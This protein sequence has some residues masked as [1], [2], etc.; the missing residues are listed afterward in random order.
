MDVWS[1][2]AGMGRLRP[3][4]LQR[5]HAYTHTRAHTHIQS[6]AHAHTRARTHGSGEKAVVQ[7]ERWPGN[8][9]QSLLVRWEERE[10][11]VKGREAW[12]NGSSKS[13]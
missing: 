8:G 1:D 4:F 12:R 6:H 11:V 2:R 9:K 3:V 5:E 13:C 10:S 7:V